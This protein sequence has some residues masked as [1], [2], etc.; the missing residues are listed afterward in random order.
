MFRSNNKKG[1]DDNTIVE[2]VDLGY[3]VDENCKY[4]IFLV[5]LIV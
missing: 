1:M 3:V 4:C 2:T 5:D